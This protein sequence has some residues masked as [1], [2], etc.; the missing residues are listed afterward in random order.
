MD[1]D[2]RLWL[3]V[4]VVD[5]LRKAVETPTTL[6][7]AIEIVR[8]NLPDSSPAWSSLEDEAQSV[9]T[10]AQRL[11]PSSTWHVTGGALPHRT[12]TTSS[13]FRGTGRS[14]SSK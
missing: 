12:V 2:R 13:S 10:T 6:D 7:E 3:L 11:L 4:V 14:W 8:A 5:R 9:A 1:A